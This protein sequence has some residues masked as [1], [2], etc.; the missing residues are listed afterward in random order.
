MS[1]NINRGMVAF[2]LMLFLAGL[3]SSPVFA[4]GDESGPAKSVESLVK[5]APK[6]S[7]AVGILVAMT[8]LSIVPAILV[9]MT[10][11][12]R[13]IIVLGF[14]RHAL[15]TQQSPPNVVLTGISLFLTL[16][17]MA[18]VLSRVQSDAVNPYM[19]GELSEVAAVEKGLKPLRT[20][21]ARQTRQKD[22][23]LMVELSGASAPTSFEDIATTTLIPAFMISELRTAFMMGFLVFLPFMVLDMVVSAVLMALGMV[24]LPPAMISLPLKLLLFVMADGWTLVVKSLVR[25]FDM[26]G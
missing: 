23:A 6:A 5:D 13:T 16:F 20:F 21:M 4:D 22:L 3:M 12:M 1:G 26:G 10:S 2:G 25:S 19:K 24:M 17:I 7:T 8:L 9:T 14:L 11:F 15:S 18:P